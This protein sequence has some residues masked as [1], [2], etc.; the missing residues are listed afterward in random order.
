MTPGSRRLLPALAVSAALAHTPV[1]AEYSHV[2]CK[3]VHIAFD[4]PRTWTIDNEEALFEQGFIVP[5]EPLYALVTSPGPLPSHYPS[6]L[7][8]CRGYS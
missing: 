8:P 7:R 6:T 1:P 2:S 3:A 5:P 4:V